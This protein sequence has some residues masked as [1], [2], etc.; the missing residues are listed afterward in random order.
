MKILVIGGF[1]AGTKTAAKLKRLNR[2][3]DV[4]IITKGKNISY[5][6]CGLPYYM[7]GLIESPNELTVNT[8]SRYSELTGVNVIDQTEVTEVDFNTKVLTAVSEISGE[9]NTYSYDK[10]IIASGTLPVIPSFEGRLLNGVFTMRTPDDAINMRKYIS[11]NKCANAVVI[12]AGFIGLEIAENLKEQGLKVSV[13]DAADQVTPNILDR[14]VAG[15]VKKHLASQ[16]IE[17]FTSTKAEDIL[18]DKSK[19]IGVKTQNITIPADIVVL[20][21]GIQPDTA[22]LNRELRMN[23][24]LII[25]N[26]KMETNIPDVYAVGGC[27]LVSNRSI[28]NAQWSAMDSTDNYTGRTFAQIINGLDKSYT[29][30]LDTGILKLPNLNC[31][32]TGLTES[33]AKFMSYDVITATVVTDDEA[34]YYP[35]AKTFITKLIADKSTHKLLGIQVLGTEAVDKMLDI[36]VTGISLGARIEDF[37]NMDFTYSTPFSTAIHPFVQAC[38]ILKNKMN[39]EFTTFTPAEYLDGKAN[40]YKVIDVHPEPK[41]AGAKWIDLSKVNGPIESI[42]KN[43]KLLLV[44]AN[45]KRGY[46]LQ[47]CLKHFGYT[48]AVVLEGGVFVN[49]VKATSVISAIS[50]EDIKRVKALG[51]FQDKRYPDIFNVRI[52]TRNG[53]ISFAEQ[54]AIAEAAKKYGSGEVTMTSRLTLEIQG[55]PYANID[56]IRNY[57]AQ[58]GLETG[59]TGSK[60]RPVVSCK[61]TTCQYGLIDTFELSEEIHERFY[62]GYND[63]NLPHKFKIAVGGCPN[64]CVKPDL[65]DLGITGQRIPK[66]DLSKCRGCNVCYVKKNCPIKIIRIVDEKVYINPNE[67]NNCGRCVDKCPFKCVTGYANGYKVY[68]GGRWGKKVAHGKTL[69]KIFT[70]RKEVL[71]VIEKAILFF[72]DE[73]ENGERFNDTINRLGFEYVQKKLL[74]DDLLENKNK[75]LD[76]KKNISGGET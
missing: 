20:S 55:V 62:H 22:F 27:A 42:D 24:G 70:S 23:R 50:P 61:G 60:I 28:C 19:V 4:T 66:V 72:L 14:E 44:C 49:D 36:A 71:D 46:F 35:G 51:C 3:D 30:C 54:M 74:N 38:Y 48:N 25:V 73:G 76:K 75:I 57:L 8:P 15:Y 32:R 56:D 10:L 18:G 64:N 37:E 5:A 17:V 9:S 21:I 12:G 59:G 41:I 16:E 63:V 26:D 11:E 58:A 31:G 45:G 68:I 34:P 7:G 53:K 52:I 2:D 40:S 13:V 43:E 39:G 47:N 29:G 67:C 69:D 65:N 33:A 1:A 6:V